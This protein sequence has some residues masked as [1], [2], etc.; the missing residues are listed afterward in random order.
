MTRASATAVLDLGDVDADEIARGVEARTFAP[1]APLVN[2]RSSQNPNS[3]IGSFRDYQNT[4]RKIIVSG[5][6]AGKRCWWCF[7]DITP[8]T[9]EDGSQIVVVGVP[10]ERGYD[11]A[12]VCEGSFCSHNRLACADAWLRREA[13]APV[14]FRNPIFSNSRVMLN[15]M[16]REMY[17]NDADT[18]PLRP[19]ADFNLLILNGGS[20]DDHDFDAS[21]SLPPILTQGERPNANNIATV[22]TRSQTGLFRP[23][24]KENITER[25]STDVNSTVYSSSIPL[26]V[27][28]AVAPMYR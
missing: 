19:A 6:A 12:F 23:S 9:R 26:V 17:P 8:W 10:V 24:Q 3:V 11:G 1:W 21:T 14:T 5:A 2:D 13:L 4:T 25:V 28:N 7:R 22:Y 20:L 16:F 27:S 18:I 15:T